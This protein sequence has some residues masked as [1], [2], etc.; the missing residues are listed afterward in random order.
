MV[1]Y[2]VFAKQKL[3]K[4]KVEFDWRNMIYLE[5]RN[6]VPFIKTWPLESED[7]ISDQRTGKWVKLTNCSNAGVYCSEC[8][9][10]VF[11]NNFSET[12]KWKN[13]KYC[14]NCGSRME[15]ESFNRT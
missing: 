3:Q 12:M 8:G 2:V 15:N 10:K 4:L 1:A 14:P 6:G 9:K 11:K 7:K 13:F 5:F